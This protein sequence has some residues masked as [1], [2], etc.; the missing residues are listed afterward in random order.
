MQ[1]ADPADRGDQLS[2]GHQ[3]LVDVDDRA[4]QVGEDLAAAVVR[5]EHLR[6]GVEA[7]RT[8]PAQHPVHGRRPGSGGTTYRAADADRAADVA[9]LEPPAVQEQVA[10]LGE[11]RQ[12]GREPGDL[13]ELLGTQPAQ[14]VVL[15][16]D[17][18]TSGELGDG[19]PQG[20]PRLH[21]LGA[22]QHPGHPDLAA[23]LLPDLAHHRVLR[24]LPRLDLASG[25]LPLSRRLRRV[26]ATRSQA[27]GRAARRRHRPRGRRPVRTRCA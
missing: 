22:R 26:G 1:P 6:H 24:L 18:L 16:R 23:E 5:A 3:L 21:V 19:D 14:R 4:G 12:V 11:E 20:V 13:V 10:Q 7:R 8:D 15:V 17:R 2:V 27:R 25:E 9:A